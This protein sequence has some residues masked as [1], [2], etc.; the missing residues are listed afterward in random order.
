[1]AALEQAAKV[2]LADLVLDL[3]QTPKIHT[4][5]VAVVV[6]A[7]AEQVPPMEDKI[8]EE[9]L[10]VIHW[11]EVQAVIPILLDLDY[12]SAAVAVVVAT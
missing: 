7:V 2:I 11:L 6:P 4:K 8:T 12:T 1:M 9:V 3:M 10:E 5:E